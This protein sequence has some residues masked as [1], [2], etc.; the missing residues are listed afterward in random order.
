MSGAVAMTHEK[1]ATAEVAHMK[2]AAAEMTRERGVAD[3][4]LRARIGVAGTTRERMA[5]KFNSG[6]GGA[7][8]GHTGCVYTAVPRCYGGMWCSSPYGNAALIALWP[9]VR[10]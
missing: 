7:T 2:I 9:K 4:A 3:R 5:G 8:R 6:G 10:A 1:I